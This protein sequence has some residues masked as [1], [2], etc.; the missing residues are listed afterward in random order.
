M[1]RPKP[2]EVLKARYVRMS[3]TEWARFKEIGGADWLRQY[4]NSRAKLPAKYYEVFQ[5][6]EEAAKPRA[7][8]TFES[9]RIN[10]VVAFQE[11]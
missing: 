5:Q 1:P 3:D 2:L 8:K 10:G 6:S 7:P 9:K 11:T 4:V